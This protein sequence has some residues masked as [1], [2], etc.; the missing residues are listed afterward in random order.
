M[1]L[2]RG[3]PREKDGNDF[4]LPQLRQGNHRQVHELQGPERSLQVP[5]LRLRR[6]LRCFLWERLGFNT[7]CYRRG[8]RLTSTSSETTSKKHSQR[9]QSSEPPSKG[10]WR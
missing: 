9:A 10:R 7:E 1:H 3:P 4:P 5:R 6:T 2:L 8:W